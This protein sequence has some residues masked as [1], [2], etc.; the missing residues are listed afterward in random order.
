MGCEI[1]KHV[2]AEQ[3][4]EADESVLKEPKEKIVQMTI[5]ES[6]NIATMITEE[7]VYSAKFIYF[8]LILIKFRI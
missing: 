7:Q 1:C 2:E 8:Y 4:M 6:D 3:Y 5:P